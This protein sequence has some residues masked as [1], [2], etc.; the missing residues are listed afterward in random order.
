M[1]MIDLVLTVCLTANP[2]SCRLEHLYLE[3]GGSLTKCMFLA[4]PEIARWSQE[5][6]AL[7]VVRWTCEFTRRER[8]I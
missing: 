7:R 8:T 6:P 4:Q 5:H 1:Q 3:S 2:S